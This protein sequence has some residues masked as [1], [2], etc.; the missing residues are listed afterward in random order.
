MK[1]AYLLVA[2][3]ELGCCLDLLVHGVLRGQ[4]SLFSLIYRHIL[5][6]KAK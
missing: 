5:Q 1:D 4:A 3:L 6:N 2:L